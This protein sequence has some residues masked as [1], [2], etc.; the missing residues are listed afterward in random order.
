MT[1]NADQSG[2]KEYKCARCGW[3]HAA[4]P[5]SAVPMDADLPSY[6]R[7][8]NC[9]ALSSCFV[10]AVP[11]DAPDG[12]SLQPAVVPGAWEDLPT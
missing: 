10:P 2:Y 3:V 8:F 11:D 12:C 1:M 5:R 4:I 9:G 7:C 6:Q